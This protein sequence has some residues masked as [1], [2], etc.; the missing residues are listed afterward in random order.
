[1]FCGVESLT[2]DS[3]Y[4]WAKTTPDGQPGISVRDHSLNVGCVGEALRDALPLALKKLLPPGAVTL[5]ALHDVG[6]ISPGFLLKCPLWL[7]QLNLGAVAA[8]ENWAN[9]QSN[10]ALVSQWTLQR[11]FRS[12]KLHGW[13]AVV[14]AHHGR[15]NERTLSLFKVRAVGGELWEQ[16]RLRLV[17]ELKAEFGPLPENT[18]ESEAVLWYVAGLITVADWIGSDERHFSPKGGESQQARANASA[19]LRELGWEPVRFQTGQAFTTLFPAC[20]PP[21]PLQTAALDQVREPGLYVM[22]AQMGSGKTEAALAAAYE[23]I[24]GGQ[25]SGLY[26]ALP[27]QVTSNRI[28]TRVSDFLGRAEVAPDPRRLRLAHSNSWL[29]DKTGPPQ[30]HPAAPTTEAAADASAGRSWFA[31]SKRALLAPYG[32]GTI[33]QALLGIVAAKHFFVRQ[34]GLAGKVVILDELH[35]YDL[36][37]GTLVDVLIRRLLELKCTVIVLSATLTVARRR[38][39]LALAGQPPAELSDSYPLLT[40]C[41]PDK[42]SCEISF[43]AELS[44]PVCVNISAAAP[45]RVAESLMERAAAGECVL[46]VRNTVREAQETFRLLCAHRCEGGPPVGLLHSRFPQFRREELEGKWI[47]RL[48]IEVTRRWQRRFG[49]HAPQPYRRRHGCVLVATQVVEQSVDIDADHLVTDLAPTDMLLQRMGRLWRHARPQRPCAAPELHVLLTESL[50]ALDLRTASAQQLKAAFGPTG[51]VYAPYVLLRSLAQWQAR[52][53]LALPVDIRPMLEATYAEW[54]DEPAA[55]RELRAQLES[56]K[57]KLLQLALNNTN[58]WNQPALP[59]EEG[60]QTR[61]NS[62]PT[63]QLLLATSVETPT[64]G[65][66]RVALVNGQTIEAADRD[67]SFPAA[68]AIHWNLVRLPRYA[69]AGALPATPAWLRLHVSGQCALGLV[70]DG[71]I[72]WPGADA[73][74]GLTWHADEGVFIP[75]HPLIKVKSPDPQDN[76]ESYD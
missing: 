31:S 16:A 11:L 35:T 41:T 37:T 57:A 47:R 62:R 60:V 14:G 1:M 7:A 2:E 67:W 34:F 4:F 29:L 13:S 68:K 61:Y 21:R 9:H 49:S 27:T 30:F 39:L 75:Q 71:Q 20:N 26:F 46:W 69:V 65:R 22:E 53:S 42:P 74:S 36:Y 23:L 70:R 66:A 6:K 64:K 73:P 3:A 54:P 12:S 40:A 8:K 33:D 17:D 15:P 50:A 58:V 19:A 51:R 55:W 45:A 5:V 56:A 72:Y 48:G 10:H 59:D 32:V 18:P 38:E 63:A 25:A 76:Y 52:T 28:H 43:P 24:A 44:R